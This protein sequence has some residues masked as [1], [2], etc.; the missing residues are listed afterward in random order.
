[1]SAT[2][3]A[4]LKWLTEENNKILQEIKA[5]FD[6]FTAEKKQYWKDQAMRRREATWR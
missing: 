5:A 1:V 4:Y 6:R 3:I 2:E